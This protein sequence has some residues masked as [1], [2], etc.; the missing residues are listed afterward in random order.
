MVFI[1]TSA[2]DPVAGL[3]LD[4]G[5]LEIRSGGT[6]GVVTDNLITDPEN[7]IA[8][9]G[10]AG[11]GRGQL[12]VLGG[13]TFNS[14]E[15]IVRGAADSLL[16]LEGDAVVTV[17]RDAQL[18]R[19]TRIVGPDVFM[20][21]E[22]NLE[23]GGTFIPQITGPNH[24]T[25]LLPSGGA[26]L[27]GTLRPEFS[28]GFTPM[29]GDSWT[30]ISAGAVSGAFASI[31]TSQAPAAPRGATYGVAVPP[32]SA[33][34]VLSLSNRLILNVNR[35]SGAV[36]IENA[37]GDN[38][39]L[40]GYVIRSPSGLLDPSD[41]VWQ[42]FDDA[43]VGAW[44]QANPSNSSLSEL[45]PSGALSIAAGTSHSLGTPFNF[46]PTGLGQS[47]DE[48]TFE[49]S[50]LDGQI[51]NGLIEYSGPSNNLL[52]TVDPATGQAALS[53]DS[54]LQAE[55]EGYVIRSPSGSLLP[56]DGDW[57]SL[58][59]QGVGAWEEANPTSFGLSEL[60]PAGSTLLSPS[61]LLDLGSP[62][63]IGGQ[64]DLTL[65]FL[66]V[67]GETIFG[68]VAYG[69]IVP[70]GQV[71][72]TNGDGVVNIDDLNN[73]RNNFGTMGPPDGTHPG[74]SF[75]FDGQVN[76]D[77]LNNVRNNFGAG[78]APVP[79]PASLLIACLAAAFV[80]RRRWR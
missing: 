1:D 32:G 45:N 58:Q 7:G 19:N 57:S 73:V 11:A 54:M 46:Q 53:N 78:Q 44:E 4:N 16:H 22:G 13:A 70:M 33:D 51:L 25:I 2:I 69:E 29:L 80:G 8:F 24:S 43:G 67:T 26:N 39:D 59:D 5:S 52:L 18:L 36:S 75:P 65:E 49:Y 23:V 68:N 9:I 61:E 34:V 48:L 47:G 31:D 77:D 40:D 6:L 28:G 3:R 17:T 66:L 71:G 38:I 63:A 30:L 60:N 35:G 37:V 27:G 55:F 14:E 12:D 20:E 64:Q 76:I 74:D 56:D 50:T 21:V 10:E 79:E 62:F 72:D 41:G 42:S 15:L